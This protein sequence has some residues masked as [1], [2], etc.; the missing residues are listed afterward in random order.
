M[1]N[2]CAVDHLRSPV[3]EQQ[4]VCVGVRV[5]LTLH[6]LLLSWQQSLQAFKPHA[7]AHWHTG[8]E[9]VGKL[10]KSNLGFK[11]LH[12]LSVNS[13]IKVETVRRIFGD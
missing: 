1:F 12:F 6:S 3:L 10:T 2:L 5:Q 7:Q 13:A 11:Q 4:L 9:D 8:E